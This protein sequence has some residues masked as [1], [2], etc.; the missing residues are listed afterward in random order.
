MTVVQVMGV[1]LR[2]PGTAGPVLD[3]VDLDLADGQLTVLLGPSGCGKS[4]LLRVIA[5]LAVPDAG[6]VRFDGVAMDGVAPEA[7]GAVMVAQ[8]GLLFP[9]MTVAENIG[10]GLRM[11]GIAQG[12]IAAQVAAVLEQVQLAGFGARR[13][14]A[15]SGGQAQRVALARAL[16]VRP[17][18]MLLDEPL[19]NLDVHLRADMR[20][21]I[22]AVQRDSGTTTLMVT[23]D[24]A[25]ATAMADHMALML[26]GRIRQAGAPEAVYGRPVDVD[27]ARF[28]GAVT[29][30]PGLARDG[31]FVC[32]LGQ[33]ALPDGVRE[34]PGQLVIRPGAVALGPGET[35]LVG[36]VRARVFMAG[37]IRLDVQVG[38]VSLQAMVPAHQAGAVAVGAEVALYLPRAGLWVVD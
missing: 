29:L 22:R 37:Q 34:G 13:P 5:G 19:S 14:A 25:E 10:F 38:A 31:V 17:R 35:P 36:V 32:A 6:G 18:V 23:H 8:G 21:L 16:V 30:L 11:R 4:T 1:R 24:P 9:H 12:A 3:G 26:G 27:V 28:F 33:V 2:Y 7:R 15:L 20:D